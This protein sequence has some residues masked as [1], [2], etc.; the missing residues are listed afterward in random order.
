MKKRIVAILL[1]LCLM[2][3][4]MGLS[5]GRTVSA[6]GGYVLKDLGYKIAGL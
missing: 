1:C 6:D 2:I 4:T 3:P 5:L